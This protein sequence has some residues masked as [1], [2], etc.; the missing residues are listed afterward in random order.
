M[1]DSDRYRRDRSPSD[2][3]IFTMELWMSDWL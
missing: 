3:F 1:I 2:E